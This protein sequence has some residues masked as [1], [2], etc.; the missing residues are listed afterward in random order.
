MLIRTHMV[1][2]ALQRLPRP[3]V[4]RQQLLTGAGCGYAL[5]GGGSSGS[6]PYAGWSDGT[7]PVRLSV[8]TY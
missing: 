1:S 6:W 8:N 4:A 7:G 2:A 3:R 5:I